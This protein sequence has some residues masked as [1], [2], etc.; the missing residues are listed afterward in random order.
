MNRLFIAAA[1]AAAIAVATDYTCKQC[2]SQGDGYWCQSNSQCYKYDAECKFI[3]PGSGQCVDTTT[4]PPAPPPPAPCPGGS[5]SQCS[6]NLCAH[7]GYNAFCKSNTEC[8]HFYST[9]CKLLCP[10]SGN[11]VDT[12]TCGS[13][14]NGGQGQNCTCGQCSQYGFAGYCKSNGMCFAYDGQCVAVCPGGQDNCVPTAIC[15]STRL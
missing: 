12:S 15:N 3:C 8:Y 10:G 6:C 11:C 7:Y 14:C 1:F 9:E 4:C 5:G 2:Q 13:T